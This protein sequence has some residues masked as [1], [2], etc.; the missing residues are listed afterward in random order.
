LTADNVF[1]GSRMAA[2]IARVLSRV[3]LF[4]VAQAHDTET[5]ALLV[6]FSLFGLVLSLLAAR[7]D[8][9]TSWAFF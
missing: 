7:A 3:T 6:M 8:L 2:A 1:K 9:D 5:L 4:R